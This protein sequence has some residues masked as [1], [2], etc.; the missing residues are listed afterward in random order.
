MKHIKTYQI[1]EG[2]KDPLNREQI[3]WLNKCIDRNGVWSSQHFPRQI[4]VNGD[5]NCSGQ[6]LE[7]FM[8][9]VFAGVSGKF[10]CI[11]N[12]LT[13]LKGAPSFVDR[14]F[15]CSGNQLTSLKGAPKSVG[16][17]FSCGN[18][19][20]ISLEGAPEKIGGNL[21]CSDN[22]I[23]ESTL[24]AM[25]ELMKRGRSYQQAL[26]EYWPNI[27]VEDRGEFWQNMTDEDR[28]EFW[29]YL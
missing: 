9:I 24:K 12:Q 4:R 8:D 21:R 19:Q 18:N 13:S 6:N 27:S 15:L 11:N 25:F 17:N 5:F 14:D 2:L 22:P 29:D 23:S 10:N 7:N 20:L 26:H 3:D 28:E 1:F 16:G